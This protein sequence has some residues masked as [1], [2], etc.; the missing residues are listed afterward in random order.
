[1]LGGMEDGNS[2]R[3]RCAACLESEGK[4]AL[5][6]WQKGE[7]AI[8]NLQTRTSFK[9]VQPSLAKAWRLRLWLGRHLGGGGGALPAHP[10]M[11]RP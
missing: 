3:W 5:H 11:G 4:L 8:Q 9:S 1:M 2:C 10:R 7:A 6:R